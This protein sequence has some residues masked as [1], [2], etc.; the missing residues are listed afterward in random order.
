[1]TSTHDRT[2][3]HTGGATIDT[4]ELGRLR[5]EDP[6]VHVIDVRTPGEYDSAHIPGAYNVPLDTL[7]EHA[8]ELARLEHPVVLVCQSGARAT[9]ALDA[10]AA[11]GKTNLRLLSGGMNA[12]SAGGGAVRHGTPRWRLERQVRLVAGTIVATSIAASVAVPAARFVAGL[13]GAGLA[14]AALTDTCAMGSLLARLPYNRGPRCDMD[15]V[16]AELTAAEA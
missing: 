6:A 5:A 4:I 11:A 15:A 2:T 9:R 10:L 3:V 8:D 14:V 12:W 16:L 1:M 13:V 7:G